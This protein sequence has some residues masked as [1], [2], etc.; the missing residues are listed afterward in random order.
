MT[1]SPVPPPGYTRRRQFV[2]VAIRMSAEVHLGEETFTATTRD[3]SEGGV[4]LDLPR[5]VAEG[6]ELTMGLFLVVD[7]VEEARSQTVQR[8]RCVEN[9][10]GERAP[11]LPQRVARDRERVRLEGGHALALRVGI[12][13]ERLGRA[14]QD[15]ADVVRMMHEQCLIA[16]DAHP[17][18][19]GTILLHQPLDEQVGEVLGMD[20]RGDAGGQR[21][22][23]EQAEDDVGHADL[24][25]EAHAL[26]ER[27]VPEVETHRSAGPA[28]GGG[29]THALRHGAKA[30]WLP[31]RD[32]ASSG[33]W[34]TTTSAMVCFSTH[35][36]PTGE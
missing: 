28:P 13:G 14:T 5:A 26:D 33:K 34:R 20:G 11:V 3:L 7:D 22:L 25:G 23:R 27:G 17:E 29:G 24:G 18:R 9:R 19:V 15:D 21:S 1:S 35:S 32:W 8:L 2:R 16:R 4:G 30:F 31:S 10:L 36:R 6:A 12:G